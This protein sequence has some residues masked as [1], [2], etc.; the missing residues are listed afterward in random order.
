[1]AAPIVYKST[2]G[3][4]PVGNG[5]RT[6]L[7][8]ILTKCLVSGYGE[9]PPAGWTREF[10]NTEQTIAVFRNSSV[11]GN[12]VF[13]RVDGQ[14][15]SY[16]YN[17][18]V[19]AY[20]EMADID[21][22]YFS[23]D[24]SFE[25]RCSNSQ[26]TTAKEWVLIA[27]ERFFYLICFESKLATSSLVGDVY[28]SDMFFGDCIPIYQTDEHF[29][30]IIGSRNRYG[31]FLGHGSYSTSG[32]Y[33]KSSRYLDGTIGPVSCCLV[34]GG[35]PTNS[36]NPGSNGPVYDPNS[37]KFIGRPYIS[38]GSGYTVRGYYPGLYF[39]CMSEVPNLSIIN[40]DGR[41]FMAFNKYYSAA[42]SSS[43]EAIYLISLDDWWV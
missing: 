3:N 24:T 15:P 35:G 29:S 5:T 28:S 11:T 2:D 21:T 36:S 12:G 40:D 13:L 34:N 10:V 4:A 33:I 17:N 30:T 37:I 31:A 22:G 6:S 23:F 18:N 19:I 41:S 9:K 8:D 27:D 7:V 16:E 26:S 42:L 14:T 38:N 1:M 32:G 39:S 25:M 43:S 20:E